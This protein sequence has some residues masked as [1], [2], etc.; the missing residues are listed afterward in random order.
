MT[1]YYYE[2]FKNNY[3]KNVEIRTADGQVHRGTIHHVDNDQVYLKTDDSNNDYSGNPNGY[4]NFF[5]YPGS[6]VPGLI[7]IGL[8]SIIAFSFLWW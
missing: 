4:T 5:F 7:A 8:A 1:S 2:S 3:G 6:F